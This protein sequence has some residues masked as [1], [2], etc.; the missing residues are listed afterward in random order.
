MKNRDFQ[1]TSQ[2]TGTFRKNRDL[3]RALKC[4]SLVP[5]NKGLVPIMTFLV[6]QRPSKYRDCGQ[7]TLNCRGLTY[8]TLNWR[9]DYFENL[10]CTGKIIAKMFELISH[11]TLEGFP[12]ETEITHLKKG[13]ELK[14][15]EFVRFGC[16]FHILQLHI[17][18][19]LSL[20]VHVE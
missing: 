8:V 10:I 20:R 18:I 1:G 11:F 4:P 3:S 15:F 2:K 6:G 13:F 12:R 16:T 9:S 19:L 14:R 7:K 17:T 5:T